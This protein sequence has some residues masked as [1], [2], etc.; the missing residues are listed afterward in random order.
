MSNEE[1]PRVALK[2]IPSF[3]AHHIVSALSVLIA[4]TN[5]VDYVCGDCGV[6][7]LHA[8]LGQIHN[9]VIRCTACGSYNATDA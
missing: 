4:S 5:T 7:L 2:L 6:V 8:E 1:H 9:L 3:W